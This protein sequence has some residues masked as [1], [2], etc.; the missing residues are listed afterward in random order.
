ML[1][2]A[3][4]L[5]PLIEKNEYTLSDLI[6]ELSNRCG[7]VTKGSNAWTN[8][9]LTNFMER[10]AVNKEA[11]QKVYKHIHI[12]GQSQDCLFSN[13]TLTSS[14]I[15]LPPIRRKSKSG[16]DGYGPC[17]QIMMVE[18]MSYRWPKVKSWSGTNGTSL[19]QLRAIV[20]YWRENR[21]ILV[22]VMIIFD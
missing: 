14:S 7:Q 12:F 18:I 17:H 11:V 4:L 22:K 3:K 21:E 13:K 2:V 6:N 20:I 16:R 15:L 1:D 8:E 5:Q 19:E 9:Q 10:F